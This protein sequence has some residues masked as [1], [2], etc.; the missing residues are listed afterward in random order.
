M[1]TSDMT[2]PILDS[3]DFDVD[4][5]ELHLTFSEVVD[6][7]DV[8]EFML[9]SEYDAT[10]SAVNFT[11]TD[12]KSLTGPSLL[13]DGP[14]HPPQ[15]TIE[16]TDHD[17]NS[18]KELIGLADSPNTTFLSITNLAAEDAFGNAIVPIDA[19]DSLE[20][21]DWTED[22]TLPLLTSFNFDSNTGTL[23]LIFD[24]TIDV[25]SFDVLSVNFTNPSTG[26]FYQLEYMPPDGVV[27]YSRQSH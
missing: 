1:F 16:L 13:P 21:Y 24:E 10:E 20:V 11:L 4:S 8:T 23:E 17:L 27:R 6:E 2:P 22:D 15:L 25:T 7:I 5:G 14:G 19:D 12:Y 3:F 9:Q 26:T 18:V